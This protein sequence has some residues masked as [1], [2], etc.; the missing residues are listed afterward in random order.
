MSLP[1]PVELSVEAVGSIRQILG[2]VMDNAVEGATRWRFDL[3]HVQ[4]LDERVT[5]GWSRDEL[6]TMSGEPRVVELHIEDVDL[7]LHGMAFTEVMSA[8]LPWIDMVRWTA[9]FVTAQ[10][11]PHWTDDEWAALAAT[12]GR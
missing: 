1:R 4:D 7:V 5:A 12:S 10:L 6:E 11:R 9:D 2:I 3:D 8:D